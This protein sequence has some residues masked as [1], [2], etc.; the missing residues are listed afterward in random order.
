MRDKVTTDDVVQMT[1]I[2]YRRLDTWARLGYLDV[3]VLGKGR[4]VGRDWPEK[5]IT[6]ALLIDK[7]SQAGI[8]P[9]KACRVARVIVDNPDE[10]KTKRSV[11]IGTGIWLVVDTEGVGP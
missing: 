3:P 1:G 9:I 6:A 10:T 2:T 8:Q 7:M 5:E 11:R 4:N